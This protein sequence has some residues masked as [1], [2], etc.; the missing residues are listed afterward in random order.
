MGSA[1]EAVGAADALGYPVVAKLGGEGVAH[2]TERGL[3]RL[4]LGSA[5]A[6]RDAAGDAAGG[7]DAR[8]R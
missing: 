4:G 5:D 3:V 1:D 6:V 2:K 8:R 7:R